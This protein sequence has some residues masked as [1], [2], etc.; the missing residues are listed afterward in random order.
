M[1]ADLLVAHPAAAC[2]PEQRRAVHAIL[3][4]RTAAR[5]RH[6]YRCGDCQR[7]RFAYHSCHH[8]AGTNGAALP[9]ADWQARQK[10]RLLPTRYFL[11]TFGP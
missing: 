5:G 4:C 7:F 8:R 11:V 1:L 2:T 9:A 3:S 6:L 10:V